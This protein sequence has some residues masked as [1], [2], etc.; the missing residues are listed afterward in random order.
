[1]VMT[2]GV[3]RMELWASLGRIGPALPMLAD[4][5]EAAN[6]HEWKDRLDRAPHGEPWFTSFHASQFPGDDPRACDRQALYDLMA[7]PLSEP[8]STMLAGTA[9][10]GKALEDWL[11]RDLDHDGRLL[12]A[13]AHAPRQTHLEDADSWLVAH[14]DSSCSPRAGGVPT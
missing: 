6:Q 2:N 4:A 11:V 1:M 3:S 13:P 5:N 7:F 12:S 8:P 9:V 10:V 14:P